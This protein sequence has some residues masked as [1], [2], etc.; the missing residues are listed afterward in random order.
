MDISSILP[1]TEEV[2]E[3]L[4]VDGLEKL[5]ESGSPLSDEDLFQIYLEARADIVHAI[6]LSRAFWSVFHEGDIVDVSRPETNFYNI[7]F[8]R[9]GLRVERMSDDTA[10]RSFRLLAMREHPYV[11]QATNAFLNAMIQDLKRP[12]PVLTYALV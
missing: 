2:T 4:F 6:H 9:V 11:A 8:T 1:F 7:L 12:D 3:P 10:H 5:R